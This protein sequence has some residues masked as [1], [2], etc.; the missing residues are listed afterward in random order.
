MKMNNKI[1]HIVFVL[2]LLTLFVSCKKSYTC[3]CGASS[4]GSTQNY[5]VEAYDDDSSVGIL[6]EESAEE[7]CN[8]V[9]KTYYSGNGSCEI[10]D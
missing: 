2:L 9:E 6:H 10:I 5:T 3:R 4:K 1:T 8:S 7:K